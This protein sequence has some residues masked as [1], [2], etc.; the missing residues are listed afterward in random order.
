MAQRGQLHLPVQLDVCLRGKSV[1]TPKPIAFWTRLILHENLPTA[2]TS[3]VLGLL[4]CSP[5][6]RMS[7]AVRA[8]YLACD[9]RLNGVGRV[10]PAQWGRCRRS[11]FK[12][13]SL[14]SRSRCG[15]FRGWPV[16]SSHFSP[17]F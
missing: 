7:H 9:S 11:T 10:I 1:L 15:V 17:A 6:S 3:N 13:A 14:K 2:E 8:Y 16:P 4:S 12:Y 5:S